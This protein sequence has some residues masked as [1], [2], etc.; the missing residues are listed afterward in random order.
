MPGAEQLAHQGPVRAFSEGGVVLRYPPLRGAAHQGTTTTLSGP[1]RSQRGKEARRIKGIESRRCRTHEPRVCLFS[2]PPSPPPGRA[3]RS[4]NSSCR[5]E[6][7]LVD[8]GQG[9]YRHHRGG[10]SA[11]TS[12]PRQSVLDPKGPEG[13]V[14]GFLAAFTFRAA[15]QRGTAPAGG[16]GPPRARYAGTWN[17]RVRPGRS[18]IG[19]VA[20]R[21]I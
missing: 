12:P 15:R 1:T 8:A 10:E 2:R 18:S 16:D 3:K 7:F 21:S 19:P 20:A 17:L 13:A 14:G 6:G 11:R 4:G 9:V 5:R